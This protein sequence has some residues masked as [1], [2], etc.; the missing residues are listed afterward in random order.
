MV[1]IHVHC[2]GGDVRGE[3][4]TLSGIGRVRTVEAAGRAYLMR[5]MCRVGGGSLWLN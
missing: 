5:S 1:D 4:D 2:T 3:G